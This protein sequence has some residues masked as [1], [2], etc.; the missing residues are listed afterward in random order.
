MTFNQW[1]MIVGAIIFILGVLLVFVLGSLPSFTGSGFIWVN[2]GVC[3]MIVGG[4][5]VYYTY[6]ENGK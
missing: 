1:Y 2:M 4:L 5:M 6:K 3:L